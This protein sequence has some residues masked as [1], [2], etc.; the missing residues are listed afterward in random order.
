MADADRQ[1]SSRL[2]DAEIVDVEQG[3]GAEAWESHLTTNAL[4]HSPAQRPARSART[5]QSTDTS[6]GGSKVQHEPQ[7][8]KVVPPVSTRV[9]EEH[10]AGDGAGAAPP[11]RDLGSLLRHR[12]GEVMA[13]SKRDRALQGV[14]KRWPS[15]HEQHLTLLRSFE[16]TLATETPSLSGGDHH[17][18]NQKWTFALVLRN[19]SSVVDPVT[20]VQLREMQETILF[21]LLRVHLEL[22]V[23]SDEHSEMAEGK[24]VVL[25]SGLT[26]L[27]GDHPGRY[28]ILHQMHH[29][30]KVNRYLQT[31]EGNPPVP[32]G[33]DNP[34]K[35][36][37]MGMQV[38]LTNEIITRGLDFSESSD[39]FQVRCAR[40]ALCEHHCTS[41][42]GRTGKITSRAEPPG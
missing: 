37:T 31:G 5:V 41:H 6:S 20:R 32:Y 1:F 11:R 15:V 36:L 29:L 19:P 16:E 35:K 25:I 12:A 42:G 13:H 3:S 39:E 2:G 33:P 22:V 10:E 34:P 26:G 23:L 14:M 24:L 27:D 17:H 8:A 18:K 28:S 4:A 38:Y 21:N 7:F 9:A 40:C 30:L